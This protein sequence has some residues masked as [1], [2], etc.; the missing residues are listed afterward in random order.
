MKIRKFALLTMLTLIACEQHENSD[1]MNIFFAM[2]TGTGS[3]SPQE[4][5]TMLKELGYAGTDFSALSS[6]GRTLDQLPEY[7]DALDSNRLHLFAVYVTLSMDGELECPPDINEAIKVLS[8]RNTVLWL[9]ITSK[10]FEPGSEDG[11]K[12]AVTIISTIAKIA[13]KH[14]LRIALYPHHKFYAERVEDNLRLAR[15]ID[16]PHVGLTFNLCH[17]LKSE[18]GANLNQIVKKAM[19]YLIMATINGADFSSGQSYGW[20]RLIQ[21]LDSG[22]YDVF[23]FVQRL[24]RHGYR[25]PIGLQGFGIKGDPKTILACSMQ[26]WNS[27]TS[28]LY[29]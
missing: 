7:L 9:A 27:F 12:A 14:N 21:P 15:L 6:F 19:P 11:D 1:S 22:N 2:D 5:A 23:D 28:K 24:R 10:K 26:T 3:G 20:D 16:L 25:G 4:K 8:G 17:S 29:K 18:N 13:A